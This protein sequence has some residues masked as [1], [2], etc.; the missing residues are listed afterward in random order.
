MRKALIIAALI[1]GSIVP[2]AVTAA[3]PLGRLFFTPRQR[4]DL[5]AGKNAGTLAPVAP[6]P[7]TV[8][9][10][11]VV[12]RSDAERTVWIN[13]TVYHDGSPAGV[14]VN[15]SPG[16]P[17]S[18]S[19]RITGKTATTRVKVGQQLDL[20]SGQI[21]EDF[22]RRRRAADSAGATV[23]DPAARP[24]AEK[25]LNATENATPLQENK[26]ANPPTVAR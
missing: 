26:D 15:T 14:Q 21:R 8:H 9:L 12:T 11:G 24:A 5:D 7:R 19:I 10:D 3:E 13:G 1:A 17:A 16:A 20:N 22:S 25:K 6:A 23:A 2:A 4:N 18:T